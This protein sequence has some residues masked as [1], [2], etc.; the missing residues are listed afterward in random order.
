MSRE[1]ADSDYSLLQD[2]HFFRLGRHA[3]PPEVSVDEAAA[4][5]RDLTRQ[6]YYSWQP[7][8]TLLAESSYNLCCPLDTE[9]ESDEGGAT[10]ET[11]DS[12]G[13]FAGIVCVESGFDA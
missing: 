5:Q 7:V 11:S 2:P 8:T 9:M 1:E 4:L 3:A 10:E 6:N 12:G 13:G